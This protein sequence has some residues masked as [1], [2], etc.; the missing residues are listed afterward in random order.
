MMAIVG[1][2]PDVRALCRQLRRH[3]APPTP[4]EAERFVELCAQFHERV[5]SKY[6]GVH[7]THGFNRTGYVICVYLV[8][9]CGIDVATAVAR[10][11]AARPPGIQKVH[12]G[13]FSIRPLHR[14]HR[15]GRTSAQAHYVEQLMRLYGAAG[16][17]TRA[18]APALL[19]PLP[20]NSHLEQY[21]VGC[22]PATPAE[23]ETVLSFLFKVSG[24]RITAAL[25]TLAATAPDKAAAQT[26][27]VFG[28]CSGPESAFPGTQVVSLSHCNLSLLHE[29]PYLG[30]RCRGASIPLPSRA[31]THTQN[32][33]MSAPHTRPLCSQL[34]NR[35][36][37]ISDGDS[38]YSRD[39]SH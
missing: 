21:P 5:P 16:G 24:G 9:R 14:P 1:A 39:L 12:G 8:R 33:S 2:D 34:E 31:R 29:R 30:T 4:Q 10:F 17:T 23:R 11:A 37:T 20:T 7:C 15:H 36:C 28:W 22:S 18:A 6:I 3:G 32:P 38:R 13:A 26:M 35:R 25:A 19:A 27:A